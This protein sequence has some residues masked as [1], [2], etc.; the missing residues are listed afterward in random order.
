MVKAQSDTSMKVARMS[1]GST[2]N[3]IG[4]DLGIH[5]ASVDKVVT[6]AAQV[7]SN[8]SRPGPGFPICL[9]Y[10]NDRAKVKNFIDSMRIFRSRISS[11]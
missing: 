10:C 11:I 7:K 4:D 8:I 9:P 3:E 1:D 5:Y 6:K 2:L